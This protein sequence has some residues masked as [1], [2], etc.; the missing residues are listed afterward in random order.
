MRQLCTRFNRFDKIH[1]HKTAPPGASREPKTIRPYLHTTP[2]NTF[3]QRRDA[4][5]K[6]RPSLSSLLAAAATP[7]LRAN[8]TGYRVDN[9][10]AAS[11]PQRAPSIARKSARHSCTAVATK[12]QL[13]TT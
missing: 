6:T 1:L 8:S 13:G 2:H 3:L 12:V 10:I 5:D 4:C 9:R 11:L 7:P